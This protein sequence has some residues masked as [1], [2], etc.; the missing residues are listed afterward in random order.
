MRPGRV[1][2]AAATAVSGLALAAL[3]TGCGA[4]RPAVIVVEADVQAAE[5]PVSDQAAGPAR[6][7]QH[8]VPPQQGRLQAAPERLLVAQGDLL[9]HKVTPEAHDS[10]PAASVDRPECRELA[11]AV[12]GFL[13]AG[14]TGWAR[15]SV[16]AVAS[17]LPDDAPEGQ[18]R[19]AAQDAA[20]STVT[21]VTVGSYAGDA[22]HGHFAEVQAAGRACEGGYA[23]TV[24][25]ESFTVTRV[26]PH[27]A[28]G[29]DESLAYTVEAERDGEPYQTELMVVR[30]GATLVNF[31]ASRL[32]GEAQLAAPAIE[33]QVRKLG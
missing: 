30:K 1:R 27:A 11:R 29:G 4:G 25:G 32:S 15:A 13:P 6:K 8:V 20:S 28:Y 12:S 18:K 31:H 19:A 23:A 21:V 16:V 7:G 3:A 2:R 24:N 9:D 33:A 14:R 10:A 5:L 26:V 22:A 17:A